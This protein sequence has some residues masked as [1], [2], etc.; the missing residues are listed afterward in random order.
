MIAMTWPQYLRGECAVDGRTVKIQLCKGRLMTEALAT[1]L[2]RDPAPTTV[3]DLIASLWPD[4]DC[5]PDRAED[6]A[7]ITMNRLMA[8]IGR[9][10]FLSRAP[11][12]WRVVQWP[13]VGALAA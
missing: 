5:E 9:Y 12:G 7:Y 8:R 10:H 6:T 3:D 11:F 2:I 4:P 1:L 13:L